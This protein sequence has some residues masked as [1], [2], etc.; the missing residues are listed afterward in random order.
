MAAIRTK[1]RPAC[2][3]LKV[4]SARNLLV[5]VS[6]RPSTGSKLPFKVLNGKPGY[7]N[8]LDAINAW[9]LVKEVRALSNG[10]K[11]N[12]NLDDT[13]SVA[14]RRDGAPGG[15]VVQARQPRGRGGG[16]AAHGA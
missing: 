9:Y 3:A 2:T 8:L 16:R 12:R 6:T 5:F 1:T 15:G 11:G 7:I 14:A 4:R 10:A 13:L